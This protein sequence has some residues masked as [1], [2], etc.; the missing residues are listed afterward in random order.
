[1]RTNRWPDAPEDAGWSLGTD[2]D[3]LRELECGRGCVRRDAQIPINPYQD[4][5][6]YAEELRTFVRRYRE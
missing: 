1:M 5:E 4:P 3:H 6:L 2:L